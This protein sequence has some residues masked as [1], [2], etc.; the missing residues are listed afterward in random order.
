MSST[1]EEFHG[2]IGRAVD[3]SEPWWPEPDLPDKDSP[4]VVVILLDD[5]GFSHLGSYGSFIDTPTFDRLADEGLRYTNFHTTALCSPTRA[6]LLTG[7]NHHSVGMR[8]LSNFDTGFPNM[9]GRIAPSAATLAQMLNPLGYHTMAVGKWHLAPMREASAAGPFQNWPLQKGFNRFYG[10]M[11]GE[12][13]QFHPELC[14]DN[15]YIDPPAT[16]EEGYHLSEDLVEQSIGMI[17]NQKS[18]V[19]ER[20]FFLY[21]SFGA[22]HAPHQAPDDYLAKYRGKFDEGWDVWRQRVYERQLEMG[23]IPPD[24]ELS[25]RNPGVKPWEELSEN[26]QVFAC[27]LQEAF[28]AFLEHT[29]T[30]VGRLLEALESMGE[31]DNTV[32]FTLSDNGASQEGRVTGVMDEFRYFNNIPEDVDEAVKRLDDIGTRRSFT[33]YPWGWAQVGNTPGKRYKQNTHSGGVRDPLIVTWPAGIDPACRGQIRTQFHHVIDITPT[34]LE[35]LG[36]ELPAQVGGIEQQPIEGTSLAYTFAPAAADARK[37]PTTKTSQYFEMLGHRGIWHEGWK[38]VTFHEH[39]QALDDDVWELYH[40]DE[41]FSE[42]ND[43]AQAQPEKLAEMVELFWSEAEKYGV[44]PIETSLGNLGLFGGHPVRGTPRARND[45]VYRPPMDR[46]PSE[47]APGLG[48]RSWHLHAEVSRTS[49]EQD[50]VI[51]A[52][53]TVNNGLCAYVLDNRLVYEHNYF[54]TRTIITSECELPVGDIELGVE[55]VRVQL[56]PA[57]IRLWLDGNQVGEGVVP[58]VATMISSVGMDVGRNISG[59]SHAYEAPF[60]FAGEIREI[61]IDTVRALRKEDEQ[62]AEIRVAMGTQ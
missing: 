7:R 53:G 27:R 43:L 59:V 16:P 6:C 24:T 11:N 50:G 38:A 52:T 26:E 61:R 33:N 42:V 4:N 56:G 8:S 54:N 60:E 41:D 28:A 37:V 58:E 2:K 36:T 39:T 10:F 30:Q 23:V 17:R 45:F 21:L 20:P 13:D 62:A 55:F 40:L 3:D 51:L 35:I 57:Q 47:S 48:A 5:T 49:G 25:P 19:Q 31:L 29:D 9:R 22:T 18:L 1:N 32:I 14:S 44:L 46:I 12:T 34:V 15:H